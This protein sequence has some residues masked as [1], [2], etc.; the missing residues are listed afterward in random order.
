MLASFALAAEAAEPSAAS[1]P[2]SQFAAS[3]PA[4][5]PAAVEVLKVEFEPIA[6]ERNAVRLQVKNISTQPQMFAVHIY[7]HNPESGAGG[8]GWGQPAFAQIAPGQVQWC[9]FEFLLWDP[10]TDNAYIRLR[11][12]NPAS[13]QAY[14]YEQ[15]FDVRIFSA[16]AL[17]KR[18]PAATQPA[19]AAAAGAAKA[20]LLHVQE[21]LQQKDYSWAW[22]SLTESYRWLVFYNVDYFR[23]HMSKPTP[24]WWQRDDFA[25]LTVD[26]AARRGEA[27]VLAAHP[28]ADPNQHWTIDLVNQA[29][30]WKIDW[31]RGYPR[32][33]DL[34]T[35]WEDRLLPTL[36]HHAGKGIDIYCYKD[37]SAA[38]DLAQ[39]AAAREKAIAEISH[40]LGH[41]ADANAAPPA[42]IRLVLFED[43][44]TKWRQTGHQGMGWAYGSTMV[45]VYGPEGRLDPFHETTHV[46]MRHAGS[47][48]A[49]YNE[50][51]AVYMSQR[52]GADPLATLGGGTA[53]LHARARQIA[54]EGQWISLE[55]LL[56]FDEIGSQPNTPIAYAQAG[57][58]VQFLID[59]YG[60]DKFLRLYRDSRPADE[61]GA[62]A[63]NTKLLES[64][65]GCTLAELEARWKTALAAVAETHDATKP[66][67]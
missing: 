14:D 2:A 8:T 48:P 62:L 37:S 44:P 33:R 41:P 59:T 12:Y 19:D 66:A 65:C 15:S 11:F 7:T 61:S 25:A 17:K 1:G 35:H 23:N 43:Q 45:E 21:L 20:A 51:F 39:I 57:S 46:L 16:A 56:G 29:G 60:R 27:I 31:V 13:E 18:K 58:F 4:S 49:A 26:S 55:T 3:V 47:P 63:A 28:A 36:L 9:R 24:F 32:L 53:S 6:A 64:L 42:R 30:V 40:F 67:G 5:R 52:L 10:V 22:E 50:G 34:W 54:N 38:R